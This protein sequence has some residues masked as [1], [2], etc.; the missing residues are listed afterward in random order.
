MSDEQDIDLG[1]VRTNDVAHVFVRTPDKAA[2]ALPTLERSSSSGKRSS[3]SF[4]QGD[5]ELSERQERAH[6]RR[7]SLLNQLS[8][9]YTLPRKYPRSPPHSSRHLFET[10]FDH[11]VVVKLNRW[12]LSFIVGMAFQ[13]SFRTNN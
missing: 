6:A 7:P 5:P 4:I 9:S 12:V 8:R 2:Y 13:S 3:T 11:D 10:S 1:L